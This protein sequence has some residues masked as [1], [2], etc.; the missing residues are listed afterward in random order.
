[1]SLPSG[2]LNELVQY[3][4]NHESQI[5]QA[6]N[7]QDALSHAIKAADASLAA[8]KLTQDP[9]ERVK[10]STKLKQLLADAE[11]IKFSMDWRQEVGLLR[12]GTSLKTPTVVGTVRAS[13]A[14]KEPSSTR[15]LPKSE[16][17]LLLK[18]GFLNGCKFPPWSG[19][20][21][22]EEFDLKDGMVMFEDTAELPLSE[23]QET[24]FDGWHRPQ[25]ALPPPSWFSGDRTNPKPVMAVS[26]K[27]DLIQDASTDCSVVASLCAGIARVERG[28]PQILPEILHPYDTER[29]H[30]KISPNGKYVVR[31]NFNGCYRKV[32][33]DDRLPVSSTSRIIHVVDR[34]NP[35]LLWPALLEK[36]YLKVRGGYDFPGSNSGT[37]L[38]I[39]SGWVPE[40]VFLQSDDLEPDRFWARISTAF[41]YGDVLITI[42]TGKM[43]STTEREL[44]LA[45]EHDYAVLELREIDGQRL[46]LIKNPW[47]E[48]TSWRGRF[49]GSQYNALLPK[50]PA[51]KS[52]IELDDGVEPLQNS[53]DLLNS[54]EQLSPGT[55]WMDL[56]NILQHFES[57]YLNW[58]PGLF[59]CRQDVHFTWDL[60]VPDYGQVKPRGRWASLVNHPQYTVT[61]S[62]GGTLWILLWRHFRNN[63]PGTATDEQIQ[64]GRHWIDLEGH[65]TLAAFASQGHKVLLSEKYL[66][67]SWYV[68]SPQVLLKLDD[69]E[70]G[71]PYTVVPMEEE[72]TAA[73]H[74]FTISAFSNSSLEIGFA[75]PIYP[76]YQIL[77]AAWTK[78][79]AGGN[80]HSPTYSTNP[81]FS[82]KISSKINISLLLETPN[83]E[84]NVH[85][86]LLYGGGR[87]VHTITKK[88]IVFDSNAYRRGCCVA[89][90]DEIEPGEYTI[91][92]STFEQNQLA[93]FTLRVDSTKPVHLHLLPREGAGR[94]QVELNKAIF[95]C[96]D[97]R[98]AAPIS[99]KRLVKFYAVARQLDSVP[100]GGSL[101]QV[102]AGRS[103]ARI[104]IQIGRGPQH[105]VLVS[106]GNGEYSDTTA[107]VRTEDLDV[108]PE[109]RRLGDIWLV[110]D[111]MYVSSDAQE[112]QFSIDLYVDQPDGLSCGDW[113]TWNDE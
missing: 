83:Q 63:I 64:A 81:Q 24:V 6:R 103:L 3:I 41:G 54:D 18:S 22:S 76:F 52:L 105:R 79:S 94:I 12:S 32:V 48:G 75:K 4:S 33:I 43:S 95:K 100:A 113:R 62:K 28:H 49:N 110:L 93:D 23:F 60:S 69:C 56:D 82:I 99:A 25:D 59:S 71:V 67:K 65:I 92:C 46:M 17:I 57:I 53:R 97:T 20:P 44:G 109:M 98:V 21:P 8:L 88:D 90:T 30:P 9:G 70:P 36:A 73:E 39:L 45:S 80:A 78:E 40:Q 27:V 68:D 108:S 91:I 1:M 89:N 55:F 31:L 101:Q 2:D 7:R 35:G 26:R 5:L 106:S 84:L 104:S 19:S 96:G 42:G 61:T 34:H 15:H 86:K 47:C 85:V 66:K 102:A 13:K 29:G 14:L 51:D 16:Q 10:H 77:S 107:G 111:R 50:E 72:L 87:R 37:D 112:D 38:W 11:Q 74:Y 58:N